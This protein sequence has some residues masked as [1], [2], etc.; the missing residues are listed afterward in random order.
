MALPTA[1]SVVSSG[2][3]AYPTIYYDRVALDTLLSNLFFYQACELKTMPDMSGVAMQIFSYTAAQVYPTNNSVMQNT[4]ITT[5][6]T[7][8][9]PGAGEALTQ[10]I[11][12]INLANYVD[13]V[14]FSNKV[15]LTNISNTVAEGAA[16][17]AYRGAL[18]VDTVAS[19]AFDTLANTNAATDD[20][21]VNDGS[22][23]VASVVRHAVWGLRAKNVKP[24]ANGLMFGI[25]SSLTAYDLV[26]DSTAAGFTDLQKFSE[27][28]ATNNPALAGIRGARIGNV[29]GC[30]LF[31]SNAVPVETHW[32]S[33]SHNAYHTYVVG[34]QAFIASSLG[35]TNL[36]QKNFSVTVRNF[37]LGS[38]S[39]DPASLIAAAAAY[40][41]FFGL[42]GAPVPS[43]YDKFRRIRSE[44]SIG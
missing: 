32:Q 38:N 26:N 28:L 40:N 43:G 7:E 13:Y 6:A 23:L 1:A 41:F 19:T 44:S 20:I 9:T 16:L 29:G 25:T 33:S 14:S 27:S 4:G 34:H 2:L 10:N 30:E 17:L 11:A 31:E 42:V 12:T 24:K 8:G 22:Y 18:T 39:L 15:T 37:P 5:A 35:K 21:E 3:E 36:N